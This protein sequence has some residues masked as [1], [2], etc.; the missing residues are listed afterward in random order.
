MVQDRKYLI[1]FRNLSKESDLVNGER[2]VPSAR[3]SR[4]LR[5]NHYIFV[6]LA[7]SRVGCPFGVG[8]CGSLACPRCLLT[9][10]AQIVYLSSCEFCPAE[11]FA[12]F[13][14]SLTQ[15]WP[16]HAQDEREAAAAIRRAAENTSTTFE[17]FARQV[18][19]D[20]LPAIAVVGAVHRPVLRTGAR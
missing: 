13:Q 12:E 6:D 16:S 1:G 7:R 19:F 14:L 4:N 5:Q 18:I 9:S 17:D 15:G 20:L 2:P 8:S 10:F 3:R 11:D